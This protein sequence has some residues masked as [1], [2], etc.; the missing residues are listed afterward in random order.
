MSHSFINKL[1]KL[2][3]YWETGDLCYYFFSPVSCNSVSG[4]CVQD[5]PGRYSSCILAAFDR[6]VHKFY[7]KGKNLI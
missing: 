1:V 6:N 5:Y 4:D 2:C 3:L 7:S